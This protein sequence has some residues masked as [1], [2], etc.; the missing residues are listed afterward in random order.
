MQRDRE[1]N[2]TKINDMKDAY[3]NKKIKIQSTKAEILPLS[4]RMRHERSPIHHHHP[5]WETGL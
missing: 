3:N 5:D 2:W 1:M 4:C